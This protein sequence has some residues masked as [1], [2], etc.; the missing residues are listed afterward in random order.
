MSAF[1]SG[2]CMTD[3]KRMLFFLD[4]FIPASLRNADGDTP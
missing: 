2:S 3:W 4:P 1:I